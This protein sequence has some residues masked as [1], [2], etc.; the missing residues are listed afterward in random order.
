[1][2]QIIYLQKDGK[3]I[4]VVLASRSFDV[5]EDVALASWLDSIDK[6][7]NKAIQLSALDDEIVKKSIALYENYSDL[8]E[9]KKGVLKMPLW[10]GIY[11][12][13]AERIKVAPKFNNK[14]ELIKKYWEDR[15][16]KITLYNITAKNAIQFI[17]EVVALMVSRGHLS[18][19][20]NLTPTG[21]QKL[22]EA[23]I[24]I[25]LF[26]RQ[27]QQISFRH[28]ALFDYQVGMKLFNA[29]FRSSKEL[30]LEIG[31]K[32]VQTLTN[33]EHLRYALNM[34]LESG[35]K[36]FSACVEAILF[37]ENIR[38][39]LKYLALNV[40]REIDFLKAPMKKLIEK[41]IL[42]QEYLQK[43]L[44]IS[45]RGNVELITY[46]INKHKISEWLK[47]SDDE[48]IN[49]SLSLLNSISEN[50]PRL[51]I[52]ELEVF[53]GKSKE[54]NQRIY[55]TLPF[56]IE[57]D[58]DEVFELR[59]KLI[60]FGCEVGYV[61]WVVLTKNHPLR[62]WY[63]IDLVLTQ[64]KEVFSKL[65][66]RY[67][68][69]GIERVTLN[70]DWTD[71][72]IESI[73]K[74]AYIFPQNI[75]RFLLEYIHEAFSEQ[76]EG[77]LSS[78]LYWSVSKYPNTKESI[79][80]GILTLIDES[81]RSLKN[82]KDLVD[83]LAPYLGSST[84]IN[85]HVIANL[86]LYLPIEQ[87]DIVIRWLLSNPNTRLMCGNKYIEPAWILSGK[88]IAKFS[89]HCSLKL[90]SEL[91]SK[92]YHFFLKDFEQIKIELEATRYGRYYNR[93]GE[94]QYFLLPT[95]DKSR[96]SI[97]SKELISVLNRKFSSYKKT[98]FCYLSNGIGG[99]VVSPLP[100]GNKLSNKNWRKLILQPDLK[101][102]KHSLTQVDKDTVSE[103]TIETFSRDLQY[104]VSNEPI[105]FANFAL[106]LPKNINKGYIKAFFNG[107]A[108]LDNTRV[109]EEYKD[110]WEICSF[111]LLEKV[112]HH[113]YNSG[114]EYEESIVLL[115]MNRAK[116]CSEKMRNI[117]INL[118]KN[119]KD[120][121]FNQLNVWD[122]EKGRSAD[123]ADV[124]EL[125]QTSFNSV[126]G[127]AYRGI[128]KVFWDDKV[129]A[130][131]HLYL[132]DDAINDEHPSIRI[133]T[134]DLLLPVL[135]YD[136]EYAHSKFIEL[137]YKDLRFACRHG[138]H[139]FFNQGFEREESRYIDLV[140]VMLASPYE[141]VR[142]EAAKQVYAR[143]FFS[144]LFQGEVSLVLQGDKVLRS[145][146]ASVVSQ[147]LSQDKYHDKIHKIERAYGVL[148][149]DSESEIQKKVVG[150]RNDNYW[151]KPNSDRLFK[152][153]IDSKAVETC[154]FEL[155]Y[156]LEESPKK[157][158]EI[159][160]LI[161]QLIINITRNISKEKSS[162]ISGSNLFSV[163][164]KIYDEATEDEDSETLN[165][166]L[167][168]WD[169]LFKSDTFTTMSI[170]SKLDNGLLS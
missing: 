123:R 112:I 147:F 143:W 154:L 155:F 27:N 64:Y 3:K 118:A 93:W 106:S 134:I 24:S 146:C 163:L 47:G 125:I 110:N 46:L 150:L 51:V 101:F 140:L 5:N 54:W 141:E 105:R 1:M 139:H 144:D 32:E 162:R 62:T 22:L 103:A 82:S 44:V 80:R 90:Y 126:R 89:P 107:L 23:L 135:N 131:E 71:K 156:Y 96:V 164:Q 85:V 70:D 117:L 121:G 21:S 166:C 130:L 29:G 145:G 66:N 124:T 133:T 152:L 74:L 120:P 61:D 69:K 15:F 142:K 35:Q 41:I 30:L 151:K 136:E 84:L 48:L 83:L 137:C 65:P 56:N 18:V 95:L 99:A 94:A 9:E 50:D 34:L 160:G 167:D 102:K 168:I 132:I 17:D 14:L 161:L 149:N 26:S 25:G 148:I 116:D 68:I 159:S 4:S 43:F 153:F 108:I 78:W 111:D 75:I 36:E 88:L 58:P 127:Q 2:R 104:A 77:S 100:L 55:N 31:S 81:G 37:N 13:I 128:S 76:E 53:M 165:I 52:N 63:F 11:L 109:Q 42:S 39:H 28:Q 6:D 119:S 91:E 79:F 113:F 7:C 40:I 157:L 60:N 138:A 73:K 57:D 169:E 97:K 8:T 114:T 49:I 115:L 87:S 98:D 158:S 10:L 45:C 170:V 38:Y 72:D 16:N 122:P 33:R 86:L 129:F 59:K 67:E 12:S 92:L 19:P 20:E